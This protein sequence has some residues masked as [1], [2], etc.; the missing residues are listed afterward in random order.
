MKTENVCKKNRTLFQFYIE[1]VCPPALKTD[2]HRY[3]EIRYLSMGDF[4]G[5][6][7]TLLH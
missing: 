5:P 6:L 7:K 4:H 1:R 2:I 3:S